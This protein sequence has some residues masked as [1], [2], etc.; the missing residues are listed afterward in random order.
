MGTWPMV[1]NKLACLSSRRVD[2]PLTLFESGSVCVLI[3]LEDLFRKVCSSSLEAFLLEARLHFLICISNV[4]LVGLWRV[5]IAIKF[6]FPFGVKFWFTRGDLLLRHL[7]QK[8]CSLVSVF[9]L[10]CVTSF[11]SFCWLSFD[12]IALAVG[13]NIPVGSMICFNHSCFISCIVFTTNFSSSS[14]SLV[15]LVEG[16]PL[17]LS[18]KPMSWNMF[19]CKI[20]WE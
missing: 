17:R 9:C 19:Y 4:I 11:C 18:A 13:F 2:R 20:K 16:F 6:E 3:S 14:L 1:I 7:R 12:W 5:E 10:V 8:A 15:G